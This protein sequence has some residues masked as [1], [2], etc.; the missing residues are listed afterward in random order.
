MSSDQ[1]TI[2]LY[3]VVAFVANFIVS[4]LSLGVLIALNI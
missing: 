4:L 2:S 1:K 3:N